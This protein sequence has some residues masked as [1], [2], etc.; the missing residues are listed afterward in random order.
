MEEPR[1]IAQL[2]GTRWFNPFS[3]QPIYSPATQLRIICR[4]VI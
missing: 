4:C 3:S 2:H 1:G